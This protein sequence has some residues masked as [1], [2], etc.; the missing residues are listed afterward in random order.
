MNA[1]QTSVRAD[2][3][4]LPDRAAELRALLAAAAEPVWACRLRRSAPSTATL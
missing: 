1:C 2:A 4:P 3:L